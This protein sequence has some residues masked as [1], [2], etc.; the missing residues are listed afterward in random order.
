LYIFFPVL[1]FVKRR[2]PVQNIWPYR[3]ARAGALV[4]AK[5]HITRTVQNLFKKPDGLKSCAGDE[6]A[7]R[8]EF[9]RS[10]RF[11]PQVAYW[12]QAAKN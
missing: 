5:C 8:I 3:N 2:A 11:S 1:P 10:L 6:A 7:G 4:G 12:A 9:V